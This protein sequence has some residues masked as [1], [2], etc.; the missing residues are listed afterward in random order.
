MRPLGKRQRHRAERKGARLPCPVATPPSC[1]QGQRPP[2]KPRQRPPAGHAA[3]Q[4]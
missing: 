4:P 2:G 3:P 1:G